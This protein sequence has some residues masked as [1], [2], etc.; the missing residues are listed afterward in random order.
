MQGLNVAMLV[1]FVPSI[2]FFDLHSSP[3]FMESSTLWLQGL[4]DL[5]I[6]CSSYISRYTFEQWG[7][8]L[9][10]LGEVLQII[11][12]VVYARKAKSAR[13]Q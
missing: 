2:W 9:A 12:T 11:Y 10:T 13:T 4:L 6:P 7:Y 1:R 8:R 5:D 3:A